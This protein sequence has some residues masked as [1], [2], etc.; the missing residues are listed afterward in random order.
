MKRKLKQI[1]VVEDNEH[2]MDMICE[3]IDEIEEVIIHK[4]VDSDKAYKYAME[5]DIDLFIVDFILDTSVVGDVSGMKF[6]DRIRT[7][8][9]YKFTPIIVTTC[10]ED[11]KLHTYSYLHCYRYFEKPYDKEEVKCTIKA[12]L[13]YEQPKEER[14]FLY[15]KKDG[16]LYSVKIRD[17][18]Y[19]VNHSI[20]I[21]IHC[22]DCVLTAPYKACKKLLDEINSPDFLQCSKNTIVNKEYILC[23]DAAN[24]Y[25]TLTNNYGI[26]DIGPKM[27]KEFTERLTK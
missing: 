13:M 19:I 6:I 23:V 22:I 2:S 3:I 18:V 12:A 8:D 10:L 27:K 16:I 21:E 15:Y 20:N 11:P 1:L 7:I 5:C 4:A 24:R 26:L 9:K 25:I 17:I 14:K